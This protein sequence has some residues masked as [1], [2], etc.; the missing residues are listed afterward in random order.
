MVWLVAAAAVPRWSQPAVPHSAAR[1]A[2]VVMDGARPLGFSLSR[3]IQDEEQQPRVP[4]AA[5]PRST[6]SYRVRD[7]LLDAMEQPYTIWS[8]PGSDRPL[9]ANLDLLVF[10]GRTLARQG[11]QKG[12]LAT[13]RRCVA[14]DPRDGRGWLALARLSE[15]DGRV[16]EAI[17]L[18][19]RGLKHEPANAHVLQ[20]A[21]IDHL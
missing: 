10:R 3:L 19:K 9:R 21:D 6:L 2:D 14:I 18:L 7:A 5:V 15:R 13:Y 12:A 20:V 16:D 17:D 4:S 1:S 11:D 8:E